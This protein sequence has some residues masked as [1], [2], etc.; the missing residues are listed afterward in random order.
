MNSE[1]PMGLVLEG[2]PGR[3][4]VARVPSLLGR[5]GP[6]KGVSFPTARKLVR[7]LKAGYAIPD[8]AALE[9]CALIWI[10]VPE[11][12]FEGA[13]A[14][15]A[16][17]AWVGRSGVVLCQTVRESASARLLRARGAK[18][19]SLYEVGESRHPLLVAE[20]HREPLRMLRRM[21]AEESRP[22]IQ[23]HSGM[24]PHFLAGLHLATDLL[25]PWLAASVECL[26][27][28]GFRRAEALE[29]TGVLSSRAVRAH[30]NAPQAPM[31]G[32]LRAEL[33]RALRDAEGMEKSSRKDAALYAAGIR[34]ALDSGVRAKTKGS[35]A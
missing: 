13:I 10:A 2:S 1:R 31:G 18:V 11:D 7:S 24:K 21:C 35:H 14:D 15:L 3:S 32:P 34:H 12:A 26:R 28:A 4:F 5:L 23:I 27:T 17:Q 16:G 22:L 19:A 8:Y 20:G 30:L 33:E 25:R 9:G 6:V 29:L